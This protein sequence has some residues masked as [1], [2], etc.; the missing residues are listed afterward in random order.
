MMDFFLFNLGWFKVQRLYDN[1]KTENIGMSGKK[2]FIVTRKVML[3][4]SLKRTTYKF[5][6]SLH[7]KC[8]LQM[9][10]Y[11]FTYELYFM[12]KIIVHEEFVPKYCKNE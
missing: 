2:Y 5:H 12:E 4:V 9:A 3:V 11:I 6:S 7:R 1:I 8:E 10:S